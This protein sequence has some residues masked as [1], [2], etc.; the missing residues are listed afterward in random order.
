MRLA[1]ET[2]QSNTEVVK[3]MQRQIPAIVGILIHV[4]DGIGVDDGADTGDQV[5]S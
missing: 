2:M 5:P 3:P 4:A 1:L